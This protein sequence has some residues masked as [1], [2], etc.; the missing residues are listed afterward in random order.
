MACHAPSKT[1]QMTAALAVLFLLAQCSHYSS[2]HLKSALCAAIALTQH[3]MQLKP[4]NALQR[5]FAQSLS[6][7]GA[8]P[9]QSMQHDINTAPNENT[10]RFTSLK[11]LRV[12]V[13][14]FFRDI[15]R[16]KPSNQTH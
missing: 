8:D 6:S 14:P 10:I 13:L 7:C 12:F 4:A 15:G 2:P 3:P 1:H 5:C 9:T 16:T 11:S